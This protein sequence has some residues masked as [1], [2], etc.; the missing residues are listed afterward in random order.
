M[1]ITEF[2]GI[3]G[4]TIE[5]DATVDE[6]NEAKKEE[7]NYEALLK[8]RKN[9]EVQKLELLNKLGISEEEAAILFS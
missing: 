5:R 9:K 8:I 7:E 3:S 1:K 4:E 2:D 6:I